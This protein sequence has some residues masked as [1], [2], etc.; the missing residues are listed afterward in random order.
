MLETTH[1][2][3]FQASLV[4]EAWIQEVCSDVLLFIS[5]VEGTEALGW[6]RETRQVN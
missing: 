1:A 3:R 5:D 4:T 6:E 2:L